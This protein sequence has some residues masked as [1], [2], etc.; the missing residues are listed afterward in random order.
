MT[1]PHRHHEQLRIGMRVEARYQGEQIHYP[2]EITCVHSGFAETYDISYDDGDF[3]TGVAA[4][5]IRPLIGVLDLRAGERWLFHGTGGEG[6]E[7]ITDDDF[8][9]DLSGSNVGELFGKGI[10]LAE[11]CAKA[12]PD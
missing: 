6:L 11:S 2:G 8:R 9:L 4:G 3:E 10:Y 5:L 12:G 7:G 1:E